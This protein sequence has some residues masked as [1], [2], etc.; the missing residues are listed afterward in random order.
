MASQVVE[1]GYSLS[2]SFRH[3]L[4]NLNPAGIGTGLVATLFSTMGPGMIVYTSAQQGKLTDAQSVSWLFALYAFGGIATMITA[5]HYRMPVVI[6][7]SIPGAVLL[8]TVL[9]RVP[10]NEAVGAYILVGLVTLVLTLTGVIKKVVEN[11]P[12][13]I[14]LGMVAGV[15]FSFGVNMFSAAVKAPQIY[16]VMLIVFFGVMAFK[17]FSEKFPPIIVALVAGVVLLGAFGLIKPINLNWAIARPEFQMPAFS[18][19]AVLEVSVPLFFLVIGVQNIQAVGVLLA[20]EYKPPINW[21]Y[22][23]P[24]IGAFINALMGAHC[25]VT[26]GPSTAICSSSAAHERKD[27]RYIA[28]FFEG[29]FWFIFALLAYIAVESVKMV[30]AEFTAVIAGLAMFEVFMSVFKGAYSG[31]FRAGA[32]VAMFIAVANLPI[33]NVGAPFWAIVFGVITSLLVERKDFGFADNGKSAAPAVA[34]AK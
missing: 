2:D 1:P 17:S 29:V 34:G 12:V 20:E 33:L 14:M 9:T 28:A 11:I 7:Y 8:G 31:K 4:K 3:L 21:M 32:V 30:P 15:L 18:L 23:V 5:L 24:S 13:P 16:G 19:R 27:L 6:A 10:L 26:A 25:A 22:F